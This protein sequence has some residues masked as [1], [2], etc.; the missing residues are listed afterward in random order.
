MWDQRS[1]S[2]QLPL[3]DPRRH[4]GKRN[5][6][7][8]VLKQSHAEE[9]KS[10]SWELYQRHVLLQVGELRLWGC[11]CRDAGCCAPVSLW[12]DST[13]PCSWKALPEPTPAL[14]QICST[15][16]K[17]MRFLQRI[18][19]GWC[20]CWHHAEMPSP[21]GCL[22]SSSRTAVHTNMGEVILLWR[23]LGQWSLFLWKHRKKTKATL[24]L[25]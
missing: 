19:G 5:I 15:Q 16:S 25:P 1:L 13:L 22:C 2:N 4:K 3:D 11:I 7:V 18:T 10:G 20:H 17:L 8:W 14:I 12:W 21:W 6:K 23:F 9:A 24:I